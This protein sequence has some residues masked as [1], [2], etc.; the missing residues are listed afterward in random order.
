MLFQE[1][2]Y[3]F[4]YVA[5][6]EAEKAVELNEVPIGAVVVYQNRIIG[7]GHNQ[8]EMLKDSTAHAEMLAITAASNN[9]QSKFLDQCDLYVTL[10]PCVMCC[11]A[12]LLTRINNIYFGTYEPKFG[13]SGSLFNILESGKYNHK[14][15]VFS[16][17]YADESKLLIEKFFLQ[18]RNVS[19]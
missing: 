3:K 9:L 18:K 7:R 15:N 4:M 8:V 19:K 2:V 1:H 5:L 13:A 6:Q 16:G 11:G 12:I 17:I 10:E 14:P